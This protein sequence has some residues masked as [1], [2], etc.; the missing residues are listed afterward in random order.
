MADTQPTWTEEDSRLY[1]EIAPVAVPA[2]EEQIAAL[3]ALL[4][5]APGEPFR[6]VE[7]ACGEGGLSFALLDAFPR[8]EVLALD[9]SAEM[10][11]HAAERL[12]RFGPRVAVEPFDIAERDW[13]PRLDGAG[14]VLSSLAIHHLPGEGKRRLF[15]DV[16][17]RLSPRG[18]LLI[19]DLVA[20][21]RPEAGALFAA[22]WDRATE[23]R[24]VALI[25]STRL[26]ERFVE[27]R[28]NY[29]RFPDPLDQPS[30]LFEQLVW[31]REA[32]FAVADCFWLRAGHA[33]YGGYR[34][35]AAG[36][37]GPLPFADALRT[38]EAALAAT[39]HTG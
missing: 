32:G 17:G 33:I 24:S 2:R 37:G 15:A 21:G 39:A 6:A 18:A 11:A 31:L 10:R 30:P 8:A 22:E 29:Y 12:R 20:P 5:F 4:P 35:G 16:A 36:V 7:L 28:W 14:C 19:A 27:A 26:Y 23:A 3:L 9:G 34:S 13:L 38:A 1:R 25:G